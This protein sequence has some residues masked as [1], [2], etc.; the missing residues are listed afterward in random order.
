VRL[1]ALAAASSALL[2]GVAACGPGTTPSA[3]STPAAAKPT[4]AS[5]SQ[6]GPAATPATKPAASP[7]A[8]AAGPSPSTAVAITGP[9]QGEARSLNG[10][11]ATFP[12]PLYQKWFEAY[13]K[14]TQVQVNYQ[15]IGSGG[16]IKGIQDQ[17]LDFGATDAP[18]TDEQLRAAK[19]GEIFH[20]P[21][22]LGAIVPTYNIPNVKTKLN[23]T[24]ATLAGVFLGD[25]QKWN[26]PKLVADNPDLAGVNRDIV[27]VHRSDG[28]GTTF[29]F[30][31]YLSTVNPDWQK[32]VGK[33]T[34]V[35]WP[36]G[37]G[38]SGNPGVAGEI[39]QNPYS[40]GYVELIYAVQNN[41]GYGMVKNKAGKFVDPSL[42]SVTAAAAA[43][44]QTIPPDL[45]F[46]IVDAPGDNSY[47]ISTATW[48]LAYKTMTDQAK[49]IALTRMLWW[50]THDGQ[51]V[52]KD[53]AYA[54]VP[55]AITARSEEFI[56]QIAV[57]GKP[58]FPGR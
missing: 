11:G 39:Q 37:L 8:A 28:S 54:T 3:T 18:M 53:M 58:A 34:S 45:R 50:T 13:S 9:F 55:D 49:A 4:T 36:V 14:L 2:L 33:G 19:G 41:L 29:G 38:G 7:S 35:N 15:P 32:K 25:I 48:L 31:D 17:T 21:T 12:A 27:V 20:I 57:G 40:L 47:P 52:N 24:G 5:G 30:T 16:G 51:R 56:R 1:R 10:A 26:D 23:F 6:P 43:S 42:D 46:S 22:A 44:A